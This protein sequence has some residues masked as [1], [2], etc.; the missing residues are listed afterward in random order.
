MFRRYIHIHERMKLQRM[1][2]SG[3]GERKF[4][5]EFETIRSWIQI[6]TT[7]ISKIAVTPIINHS[8]NEA[9]SPRR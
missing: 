8:V 2:I 6:D 3:I 9:I 5:S 1:Q 7:L 4:E